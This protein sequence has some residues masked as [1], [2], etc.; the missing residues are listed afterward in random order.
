MIEKFVDILK[1]DAKQIKNLFI[2]LDNLGILNELLP[3]LTALKGV[4][5]TKDTFHKDNFIHTL[6]V[7]EN[8]YNTTIDPKLRLIAILHDIGKTPTKKWVNNK[9][10]SFH[11][12]ENVGGK[13]LSKIFKRLDIPQEYYA[14]VHKLIIYHGIPKELTKSVTD[15]ALRR[16]SKEIG[17]DLEDLIIFSKCDLT[18]KQIDKKER[19]LIDLEKVYNQI[20]ELRRK[21]E[22]AKWR[23]PIDGNIIMEYFGVTGSKVGIIKN[24][25]IDAI[26]SGE[27]KDDYNDAFEYMKKL[28]HI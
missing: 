2:E 28:K 17:D 20:I 25:I 22:I 26:K 11:N 16:F 7:I 10:W 18:T 13:M 27:V 8:T 5:K 15:S 12:H 9:G 23:C 4:D 6:Q 1:V 14:Y 24:K 21:D 3:E 19:Q